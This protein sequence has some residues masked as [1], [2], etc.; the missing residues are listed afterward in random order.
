[1]FKVIYSG[2]LKEDMRAEE[3]IDRLAAAFKLS[4]EAARTLI[5]GGQRHVLKKDVD[6]AT[7]E[8]YRAALEGAGLI[9]HIEPMT[10]P[11]PV[12][13]LES[14]EEPAHRAR[15]V[16]PVIMASG[17]DD[18]SGLHGHAPPPPVPGA[19]PPPRSPSGGGSVGPD[20]PP[21]GMRGP[22]RVPARHGWDW[23]VR[24]FRYFAAN[25]WAWILT[26]L[27]F[28]GISILVSLVPVVGGLVVS[29][30]ATLFSGGL[31][32]GVREQHEG[33]PFRVD[34]LFAG[35]SNNAGQLALVAVLYLVGT[36]A[37]AV[38]IGAWMVV[39]AGPLMSPLG[40]TATQAA[41]P[42]VMVE[43]MGPAMLIALLVGSLFLIPL[44]MA[45]FFAPALVVLDGLPAMTAMRLSF[46]GCLKN[47]V[48][49]L[50][51]GLIGL[52]LLVLAAIPFGLGL[53]V[54]TPAFVASVYAAYQDIYH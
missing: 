49:F 47:V 46:I 4:R 35:F 10:R 14:I 39:A 21:T 5:L 20:P 54:A 26:I 3:A 16:P 34:H 25:P 41:D 32:L 18:P 42:A 29:V 9:A 23:I 38:L 51:Y 52:V 30:L 53:L 37:I 24:G 15:S 27:V 36:L 50:L 7:A 2:Q 44:M 43:L 17:P 33:R 19:P 8:R 1:M 11:K 13:T 6:R 45:Y 22:G 28:A 31:M 48:P 40:S 12:W